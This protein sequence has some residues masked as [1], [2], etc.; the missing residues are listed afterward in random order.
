MAKKD[1]KLLAAAIRDAQALV[2]AGEYKTTFDP[3]MHVLVHELCWALR[4]IN[5]R[6]NRNQFLAEAGMPFL[7]Y[8]SQGQI[9]RSAGLPHELPLT[10][11]DRR[12]ILA[13][14][15]DG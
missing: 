3:G 2:H 5:P 12:L 11:S 6:F 14:L 13:I 1:F 10:S 7:Q 9:Y 15:Q 4:D 8:K